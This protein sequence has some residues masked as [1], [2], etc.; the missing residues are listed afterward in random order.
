MYIRHCHPPQRNKKMC[1]DTVVLHK[2]I[3][4]VVML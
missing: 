1:K 4:L 3:E 2:P